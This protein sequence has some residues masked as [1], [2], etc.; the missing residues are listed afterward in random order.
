MVGG[1]RPV[2]TG[3]LVD[4]KTLRTAGVEL[5]THIGD[6]ERFAQVKGQVD[7]VRVLDAR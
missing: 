6:V 5:Q 1:P 7:G 4:G 3:A 2:F